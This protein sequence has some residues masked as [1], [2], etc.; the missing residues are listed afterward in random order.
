VVAPL[1]FAAAAFGAY[2]V[3]VIGI[4]RARRT[5]SNWVITGAAAALNV[6]L[7]LVLIPEFGIMGAAVATIAAYGT[8]FLGMAWKAQQVFPVP[9]QWRRVTTAFGAAVALTVLA[10]V[11]DPP[12]AAAIAIV[13]VYPLVLLPLGF[14]LPEELRRMRVTTMPSR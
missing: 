1:A 13:A 3:V 14:Y 5:R 7:N 10:R 8:L 11:L 12:L 4:G 6:A 2:I 9:Y